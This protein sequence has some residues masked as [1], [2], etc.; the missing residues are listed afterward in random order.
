LQ[1]DGA[2]IVAEDA[3]VFEDVG[4]CVEKDGSGRRVPDWIASPF[5]AAEQVLACVFVADSRRA[6]VGK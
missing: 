3:V 5:V 4:R 2:E 1:R 6:A